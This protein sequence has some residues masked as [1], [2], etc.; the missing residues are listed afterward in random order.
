[1]EKGFGD[2]KGLKI[3][4]GSVDPET[5]ELVI[6]TGLTESQEVY[7]RYRAEKFSI[8]EAYR[9]AFPNSENPGVS[10]WK[11]EQKE[12]IK[13]R[14]SILEKERA[15]MAQEVDPKESLARWNFLYHL[16]LSNGDVKGMM[17]AQKHIDD[18]NGAKQSQ[19][20]KGLQEASLFRGDEENW[21]K[22]AEAL[23]DII[24]PKKKAKP[25]PEELRSGSLDLQESGPIEQD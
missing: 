25:E 17:E 14:I 20:M 16:C 21:A 12:K 6:Y 23:L 4:T 19:L 5:N 24:S 22:T 13:D 2:F 1:M 8:T 11:L 9:R 10:G 15:S 18:I 3:T 7:C